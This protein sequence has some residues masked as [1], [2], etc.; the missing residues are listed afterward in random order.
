MKKQKP[1]NWTAVDIETAPDMERAANQFEPL[2]EFDPAKVAYGNTKDPGK[3]AILLEEKRDNHAQASQDHAINFLKRAALSPAT[4]RIVAIGMR[5]Q[6]SDE[7]EILTAENTESEADLLEQFAAAILENNFSFTL[8]NWSGG[9]GKGNFDANFVFRRALALKVNPVHFEGGFDDL[10]SRFMKFADY[11]SYL[12]LTNAARELGIEPTYSGPVR[13]EFFHR[14]LAGTAGEAEG[15]SFMEP[16]AQR[17]SAIEYLT[18]DV[19]LT[20]EIAT[21]MHGV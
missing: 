4:G 5:H 18:D 3:R 11:N 21:R 17:D 1:S 10:A 19:N 13:G 8:K 12:K 15:N 9:N 20:W 7:V 2:P 14:F 6:F 16:A